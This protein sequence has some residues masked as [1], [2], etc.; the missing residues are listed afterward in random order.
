M[1]KEELDLEKKYNKTIKQLSKLLHISIEEAEMFYDAGL[2]ALNDY[3]YKEYLKD[4]E[5]IEINGHFFTIQKTKGYIKVS[6]D[7]ILK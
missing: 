1:T 3:R 7:E 6:D 4:W 2:K 5:T